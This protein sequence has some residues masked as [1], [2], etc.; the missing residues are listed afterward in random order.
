[1]QSR[2]ADNE[3]RKII[4]EQMPVFSLFENGPDEYKPVF[5]RR[6]KNK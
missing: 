5:K 6:P 1:M 3:E 4:R 2:T